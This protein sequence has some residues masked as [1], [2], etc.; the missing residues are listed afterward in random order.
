MFVYF[1][2]REEDMDLGPIHP[3]DCEVCH[4]Q[5]QPF[6][7]RLV[8]R[9]EHLWFVL[10]NLRALSY[11]IVCE[12]CGTRFRIPRATGR[13]LLLSDRDPIPFL[14]RYGCLLVFSVSFLALGLG[15]L[16]AG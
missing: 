4:R 9:Y 15:A 1:G 8:Y 13:K 7:L 16:L 14:R 12:N 10:G 3:Q 2:R 11:L 6:R 5:D